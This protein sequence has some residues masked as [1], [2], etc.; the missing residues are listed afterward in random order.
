M[1]FH[2]IVMVKG[3][4]GVACLFLL[5]VLIGGAA[6]SA[7]EDSAAP[8][9]EFTPS[10]DEVVPERAVESREQPRALFTRSIGGFGISRESF[11]RPVDVD[12]DSEENFYVL[13]FGNSRVQ[14]FSSRDRFELEWGSSGH[15]EGDFDR[16]LAIAVD[17]EDAV[18]VVDTG[19]NRI[20][21]FDSEGELLLT[22]GDLGSAPGKFIEPLDI[23]FDDEG[24]V[25]ILDGGA[26][27][28]IQKFSSAGIFIE[29]WGRFQG[30]REGDFTGIVSIAWADD[31]FGYLYLLGT[32]GEECMVQALRLKGG[33]HEVDSSWI[34]PSP[35]EN[36]E[37]CTPARIEI[38]NH[39]D[40]VYILDRE[41]AVLDRFTKDGEYVDSVWEAEVPFLAPMGFAVKPR[42]RKVWVADTENNIVQRFSLR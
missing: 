39:D 22:W 3:K 1:T 42:S 23:A 32:V 25:Y 6:L 8:S 19:N 34:V 26:D 40:Y 41:R 29:Q 31:R 27:R 5:L 20:Q 7:E 14:K 38:D 28:R 17:S 35:E 13:D 4:A 36:R 15:R 2:D 10:S 33:R 24:N 9:L 11:D 18:F 12:Y 30:G 21:K 37:Q 16:P